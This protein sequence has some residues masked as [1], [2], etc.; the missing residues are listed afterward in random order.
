MERLFGQEISE[1][2]KRR[3][4]SLGFY[5]A[6]AILLV[7]SLICAFSGQALFNLLGYEFSMLISLVLSQIIAIITATEASHLH[8]GAQLKKFKSSEFMLAFMA[9]RASIFI[10]LFVLAAIPL[11][12]LALNSFRVINCNLLQG[13]WFYL[14]IPVITGCASILITFAFTLF[15]GGNAKRGYVLFLIYSILTILVT[16]WKLYAGPRVSFYNFVFGAIVLF[17]Y[18]PV[19][20]INQSFILSRAVVIVFANLMFIFAVLGYDRAKSRVMFK[21]LFQ[22]P[23]TS[24]HRLLVTLIS[25]LSLIFL[26]VMYIYKGQLGIDVDLRYLNKIMDG[27]L[28]GKGIELRFPSD[29]AIAGEMERVLKEHEWHYAA[30][31]NELQLQKPPK[32]IS[33]IYRTREQKTRLTGVGGSVFAKPWNAMIHVEYSHDD[34]MALRHELTHILAGEFGAPVFKASWQTGLSEG[35]SEAIEWEA[36][37]LT[38]HQWAQSIV[39][40]QIDNRASPIYTMKNTGFWSQ[41]VTVS[42]FISGSFVRWLIDT[43]GIDKFKTVF[44]NAKLNFSDKLYTR[45]YGK[46]LEQLTQE[47]LEFLKTVP[48]SPEGLKMA[49]FSFQRPAFA[50][51]RCSHEV[52]ER[53]AKVSFALQ[54]GQYKKALEDSDALMKFQP[55][56]P[57][58]GWGKIAALEGLKRYDEALKLASELMAH[59]KSNDGFRAQLIWKRANILAKKERWSECKTEVQQ[60][61]KISI[62]DWMKR[63]GIIKLATLEHPSEEL[64]RLIFKG[65]DD[66]VGNANYYFQKA[67]TID[68]KFWAVPYLVARR[69]QINRE[70]DEAVKQYKAFLAMD[71]IGPIFEKEADLSLL[72]CAF[73]SEQYELAWLWTDT[74]L[75]K[76]SY[77]LTEKE[78]F[79][80]PRWKD[81][82]AWMWLDTGHKLIELNMI[83]LHGN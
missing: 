32:V 55:D 48:E 11:I 25:G 64:R 8:N 81:R 60:Q 27:R 9:R 33:Y 22:S 62:Q 78:K 19:V 40:G 13:L 2:L 65:L 47:W 12:V 54:T 53:S 23:F 24:P 57:Y 38:H 6:A 16:L 59:P 21:S 51:Q 77:I 49:L 72:D 10:I 70:Y 56:D 68:P 46:S 43:Y 80:V 3:F 44:H 66:Q 45:A 29:S 26:I 7:V 36:G 75:T 61:I 20:S 37:S 39:K 83:E 4:R 5:I 69:L 50:E 35:L 14:L 63:D 17:N 31:V 15:S 28:P 82:I 76:K 18:N 30:I 41:R 34:V 74:I 71:K 73:R 79:D 42:Y 67:Q 52:A 58:H 1:S